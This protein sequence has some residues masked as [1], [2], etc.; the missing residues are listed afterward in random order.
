MDKRKL[1]IGALFYFVWS[2]LIGYIITQLITWSM[3]IAALV[4]GVYVGLKKD[5]TEGTFTGLFTGFLGGLLLGVSSL[6]IPSIYGIPI[7]IPITGFL[8]PILNIGATSPMIVILTTTLVGALFGA[9]GGF[10]GSIAE[11]KRVF[12]FL[13]LFVLFLFYTAFD[14]VAWFWG[15]E[16]WD[17]SLAHV[18]THWV[19][20]TVA[21]VFSL[22]VSILSKVLK[23]Y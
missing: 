14:N 18:L 11:L 13:V 10:M 3:V 15:K 17:W 21:L 22:F 4:T 7:S 5:Y 23:V 20:I 8:V 16:P 19:D 9:L 12:F 1:I 2:I 6:F